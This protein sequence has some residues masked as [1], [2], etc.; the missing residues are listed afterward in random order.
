MISCKDR[1]KKV[2]SKM[3]GKGEVASVAV[4]A[5]GS[6]EIKQKAC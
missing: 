3:K 4:H 6:L 5:S 2:Q 1:Q